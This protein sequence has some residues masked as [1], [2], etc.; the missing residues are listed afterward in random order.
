MNL[1]LTNARLVTME[2]GALGYLPSQPCTVVIRG[3]YVKAILSDT[4]S[5]DALHHD[6]TDDV[7]T[8]DCKGKI[9]TPGLVDPHTHL[10]FA[11]SRAEE[12]ENRLNGMSYEAIARVVAVSTARLERHGK[13]R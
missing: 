13:R 3:G 7:P 11:G 10:I 9:V 5:L 4:H 12:F 1:I 6:M 2:P 8:L